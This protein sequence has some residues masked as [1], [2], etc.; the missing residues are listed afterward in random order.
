MGT[1][2]NV[3]SANS[4]GRHSAG[5]CLPNCVVW[6]RKCGSRKFGHGGLKFGCRGMKLGCRGM[7]F[8]C[9]GTKFCGGGG[10]RDPSA[11]NGPC[12]PSGINP[13]PGI[14]LGRDICGA[15][16]GG[17]LTLCIF[18][19]MYCSGP[20]LKNSRNISTTAPA[21]N[22]NLNFSR[23]SLPWIMS[24]KDL[25]PSSMNTFLTFSNVTDPWASVRTI[26]WAA[27]AISLG[28]SCLIV[29]LRSRTIKFSN[30][31]SD[32]THWA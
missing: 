3:L 6:G 1:E 19:I 16:G 15:I 18:F 9:R 28:C 5:T 32:S 13:G 31:S 21:P 22:P 14:G 29:T 8:G 26:S 7:K 25:K 23:A 17:G 11:G 24:S 20:V 10:H 4:N 2:V 27:C 12:C 30:G